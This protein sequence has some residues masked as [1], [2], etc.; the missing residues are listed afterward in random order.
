MLPVLCL[1]VTAPDLSSRIRIDG[2][3]DDFD[4]DE[5]VL[6]SFT[7]FAESPVDSRWGSDNDISR[8]A[9][10][11][12]HNN[13]Y[14]G[15]EVVASGSVLMVVVEHTVG[16][17]SDLV[18]AGD[19]RRNVIFSRIT[20]NLVFEAGRASAEAVGAVVGILGPFRYLGPDAYSSRFF[21]PARGAGA[22]ELAIPWANIL[23]ESGQ[24]KVLAFVTAGAGTG[25]G[26][27]APDPRSLL[28]VQR[29]MQARLDNAAT[30][31]VDGD[32]DGEPDIGV[33]PRG[34]VTF[35]FI[36]T[37]PVGPG[38]G[39]EIRL[40]NP[41]VLPDTGEPLR[42]TILARDETATVQAYQTC[43]VFSSSGDRVR[44]LFRDEL[45]AYAPDLTPFEDVW[46]G[47]DDNGDIVAGGIYILN[48][49]SGVSPG[50]KSD[51]ARKS[52][53]V[54]R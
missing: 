15:V 8:I 43:E 2:N 21:Q 52:V 18:S 4:A 24:I 38:V 30:L 6:D 53:G 1:A 35:E 17:V 46:D 25:A 39:F 27:A 3:L 47:R 51:V 44:T 45:R 9:V 5:W 20:P 16:G 50:A 28:S 40:D 49:T 7:R 10:T 29:D 26:D 42:F 13:L 11:W 19:L 22:L 33:S 37:E 31:V 54:V 14:V 36:Q 12:D 41:S 34:E 48:V 23:P 32:Y